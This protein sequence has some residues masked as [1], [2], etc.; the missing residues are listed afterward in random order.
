MELNHFAE[1]H[2][3]TKLW[4]NYASTTTTKYV[5]QKIYIYIL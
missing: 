3:V 2:N 4:I 5:N 1:H